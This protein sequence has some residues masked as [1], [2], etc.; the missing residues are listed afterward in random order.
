M[1]TG[2]DHANIYTADLPAT[3][4]FYV[5]ILGLEE[6]FRPKVSVPGLWLYSGPNPIL[7]VVEASEARTPKG[8][9]DHIS[10]AV[11]DFDA[12]LGRLDEAGVAYRAID[13]PDD[14]GR[15]AFVKDP[16]GV[17]IELTWRRAAHGL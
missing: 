9:I 2:L 16:N 10:F 12:V 6:G 5:D 15:Q 1:I 11:V 7:H 17:T 3:R 14:L 4:G 13:I 8:A